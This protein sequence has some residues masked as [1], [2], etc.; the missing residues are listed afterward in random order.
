MSMAF[1]ARMN[2]MQAKIAEQAKQI[3]EL[4][5]HHMVMVAMIN[6]LQ[7]EQAD[8]TQSTLTLPKKPK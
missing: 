5:D 1:I 4:K 3:A 7:N 6:E 2:E 8:M